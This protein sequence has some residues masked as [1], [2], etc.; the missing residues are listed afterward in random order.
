M[1]EDN[2][3]GWDRW[4]VRH[5]YTA[6]DRT[7]A[8]YLSGM[9]DVLD[10]AEQAHRATPVTRIPVATAN[11][12]ATAFSVSVPCDVLVVDLHGDVD[13]DG[14]AWLGSLPDSET[15]LNLG[16]VASGSCSAA[17]VVLTGCRGSRDQ[18]RAHLQRINTRPFLLVAHEG[19]PGKKDHTPLHLVTAIL[20]HADGGDHDGAH[21]AVN[22][23][24]DKL[25]IQSPASTAKKQTWKA[26]ILTP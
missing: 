26:E 9:R 24:L 25:A 8:A 20:Y 18:F 6:A 11:D 5:I 13:K 16:E 14:R 22:D 1:G 12:I 23:A 19:K 10:R 4:G 15:F 3:L 2:V 17:A 21:T 7:Y